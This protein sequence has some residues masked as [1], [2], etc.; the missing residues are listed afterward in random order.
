MSHGLDIIMAAT[1]HLN[2][3]QIPVGVCDEPLWRICKLLQWQHPEKYGEDKLIIMLGHMHTEKVGYQ[4]LGDWLDGSGWITI[5]TNAGVLTSGTANSLINV[6]HICRARY[7]HQVT[8][9]VLPILKAWVY[10]E[11]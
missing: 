6:S 2:P 10:K 3:G 9:V 5:L 11:Y 4:I 7:A 1:E 8:A